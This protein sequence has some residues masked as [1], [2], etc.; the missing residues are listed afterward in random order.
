MK[1]YNMKAKEINETIERLDNQDW[2]NM[3]KHM[4]KKCPEIALPT[5]KDFKELVN[6]WGS[7]QSYK[8]KK[9]N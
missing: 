9:L 1:G 7:F 4:D 3:K 8:E 2:D 6:L 5:L